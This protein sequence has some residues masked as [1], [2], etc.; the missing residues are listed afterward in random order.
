VNPSVTVAK[1]ERAASPWWRRVLDRGRRFLFGH[2]VFISY[3]RADALEYAQALA[4]ALT[5]HR[6]AAYV[7]Q[8]GTP[9]GPKMPPLLLLR[10]RL[11]SMLVLVGSPGAA[12]SDAVAQEVSEFTRHNH[13]LFVVDV[14]GA[15]DDLGWY[16]ERIKGGPSRRVSAEELAGGTPSD[17]V[18]QQ[19]LKNVDFRRREE[20]LRRTMRYTLVGI[21]ALL[22]AGAVGAA[23]LTRKANAAALALEARQRTLQALDLAGRASAGGEVDTA[24]AASTQL[25]LAIESL[26][27]DWTLDGVA[28]WLRVMARTSAPLAVQRVHQEA[29]ALAVSP[30]ANRVASGGRDG[31]V[32]IWNVANQN[33]ELSLSPGFEDGPLLPMS[34]ERRLVNGLRLSP[35]NPQLL[36]VTSRQALEVWRVDTPRAAP[37]TTRSYPESIWWTEF[38][39]D[40]RYLGVVTGRSVELIDTRDLRVVPIPF[41]GR[42]PRRV[43]FSPD[44][45]FL[46]L[47]GGKTDLSQQTTAW[48][49]VWDVG[50]R[51]LA[52]T[53]RTQF[54]DNL[55]FVSGG[56]QLETAVERW[57]VREQ[58]GRLT[59]SGPVRAVRLPDATAAGY[60]VQLTDHGHFRLRTSSNVV[61]T[62]LTPASVT[63]MEPGGTWFAASGP[64]GAVSLWAGEP[65]PESFRLPTDPYPGIVAFS[66]DGKWLATATAPFS[67]LMDDRTRAHSSGAEIASREVRIFELATRR[68]VMRH[69]VDADEIRF[70]PDGRW[71]VAAD[72]STVRTYAADTWRAGHVMH[73]EEAATRS[74]M[75]PDGAWVGL[76]LERGCDKESPP[77]R[78]D[79]Y[80]WNVATGREEA[81]AWDARSGYCMAERPARVEGNA[82]VAGQVKGWPAILEAPRSADG[83]WVGWPAGNNVQLTERATGRE[84]VTFQAHDGGVSHLAFSRDGRWLATVGNNGL[85]RM[86][87]LGPSDVLAT[88]GCAR[89]FRNLT[90]EQWRDTFGEA[91]Y[92]PTCPGL[93]VPPAA[94]RGE[95]GA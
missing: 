31:A 72:A 16:R 19:V 51:T 26:R 84:L 60:F 2:D 7:D 95:T 48:L 54:A 93:P 28:A 65:R 38:S 40:A 1:N 69:I 81:R 11:S 66:P 50:A 9:P 70:T 58:N 23:I 62:F 91:P 5:R 3:A 83:R 35:G 55:R 47:S 56:S 6:V 76:A 90:P 12:L 39:P 67:P 61:S 68:L 21:V 88:E 4:D 32:A 53:S 89:L 82:A 25:L 41:Q 80:V 33:G 8:L 45:R 20:R 74:F 71:L 77:T 37:L 94:T 14:A 29:R 57:T 27:T 34:T 17:A 92:R 49:E 36:A 13:R 42:D 43:A 86:W 52:A 85:V 18:V 24:E 44:G 64:D 46:A 30:A 79:L 75:S 73:I 63:A 22:A 10:L 78:P 15:L 59:L 87:R